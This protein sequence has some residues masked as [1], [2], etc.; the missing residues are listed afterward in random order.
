M[1]YIGSSAFTIIFR[2]G[3]INGHVPPVS[4]HSI[5]VQRK[6]ATSTRNECMDFWN[7]NL[8]QKQPDT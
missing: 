4:N 2:A 8:P 7:N 3:D 5:D 6:V 1:I